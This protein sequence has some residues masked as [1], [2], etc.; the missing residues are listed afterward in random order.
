M[1]SRSPALQALSQPDFARYAFGR[2][3]STLAWQM[4]DVVILLQVWDLT[5]SKL[6]LGF[7]GLAQF[8]PFFVLL[9]P[10][11]QIADRFD[12]RVIIACAY[13]V[14]LAGAVTLLAFTLFFWSAQG[15][16]MW[17]ASQTG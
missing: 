13:S 6:S 10:G 7:V 15:L 4:V 8:L 3:S 11:G 2:L 14:E 5:H 12:R 9:L 16:L 1:N 17:K